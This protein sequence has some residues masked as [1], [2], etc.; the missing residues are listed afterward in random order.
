M[1]SSQHILILSVVALAALAA[2][3]VRASQP[4][5]R[6]WILGMLGVA[7]IVAAGVV[8]GVAIRAV[9]GT[10]VAVP[11]PPAAALIAIGAACTSLATT[12]RRRHLRTKSNQSGGLNPA[13]PESRR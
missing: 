4:R 13:T 7:G 12:L 8:G 10:I 3:V 11:W 2:D 9:D 1:R 6:D 5:V